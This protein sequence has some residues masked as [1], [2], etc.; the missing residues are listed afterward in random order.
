[1][2]VEI[3]FFV[4]NRKLLT[5]ATQQCVRHPDARK[6]DMKNFIN[7][8]IPRLLRYELLLKG[9]AE[10]SIAG[11]ED[12]DTIPHIIDVIKALGK[13]TEPG[14]TSAKQKVELW[15]YNSNLV[16]KP[17]ESI[18]CVMI[19]SVNQDVHVVSQDMDLLNQN[20]SLIHSGKLLRQPDSGLEWNGWSELFVLLFDNYSE[21]SKS[22]CYIH[23]A[24]RTSVVMTKPRERD[25]VQKYNVNRRVGPSCSAVHEPLFKPQNSLSRLTSL[26]LST[27]QIRQL[28]GARACSAISEAGSDTQIH[29]LL[30]HQ[31]PLLRLSMIHVLSF[32]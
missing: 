16:F 22:A 26:L 2:Y 25:G 18:V 29:P 30:L 6:L 20:R 17:G 14:V 13:E 15:R 3:S 10:A 11:H 8:P 21:W 4:F 28:N 1:M 9:I 32:L 19:F 7:R 23:I 27:S 24:E 12:I 31:E 5:S